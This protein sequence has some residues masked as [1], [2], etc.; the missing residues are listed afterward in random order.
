MDIESDGRFVE[1]KPW[2]KGFVPDEDWLR[3]DWI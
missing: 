3:L 1:K 2:E